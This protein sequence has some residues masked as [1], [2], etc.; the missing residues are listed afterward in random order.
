M[1]SQIIELP[2][3][4]FDALMTLRYCCIPDLWKYGLD[5]A[6]SRESPNLVPINAQVAKFGLGSRPIFR[7][8][9]LALVIVRC[10]TQPDA[11]PRPLPDDRTHSLLDALEAA[12]GACTSLT[13]HETLG[14][15]HAFAT[16]RDLPAI[17]TRPATRHRRSTK[18]S[19]RLRVQGLNLTQAYADRL[20]EIDDQ[21]TF[22]A[23]HMRAADL[24]QCVLTLSSQAELGIRTRLRPGPDG[25]DSH[26]GL[27][28]AHRR[29]SLEDLMYTVTNLAETARNVLDRWAPHSSVHGTPPT[30][31][32]LARL[33]PSITGDAW[34]LLHRRWRD[35]D[36]PDLYL[37]SWNS[38]RSPVPA[39]FVAAAL[40]RW[41]EKFDEPRWAG[42]HPLV[43]YS[44]AHLEFIRIA[45][46]RSGNR[47]A[48]RL[49][50]Q[51]QLYRAGWP[52]LPWGIGFERCYDDY[53][54]A[55]HQSM[56]TRSHQPVVEFILG[57][58]GQV[59]AAGQRMLEMLPEERRRLEAAFAT[60][61]LAMHAEREHA[62][63]LLGHVYLE[64][65]GWGLKNDRALLQRLQE[66]GLIDR[67]RTP[68]GAVFSSRVARGLLTGHPD[69]GS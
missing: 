13:A 61:P 15:A 9:V 50:F 27:L 47:R 54:N 1:A 30:I 37:G 21:V 63:A 10:G 40:A 46:F 11:W 6:S 45:P 49:L 33:Q 22:F 42:V 2:S 3:D 64:G 20:R 52:V 29:R 41:L 16:A 23:E 55:L 62:E 34:N 38:L 7:E 56:S 65:F 19:R 66:R 53:L 35:E 4:L 69:L 60:H 44:I 25:G 51:A 59:L 39:D 12:L 67:I 18:R 32:D 48:G 26:L 28:T 57:I 17:G 31:D 24:E 43:Q 14:L 8:L 36:C 5:I 68:A 58:L